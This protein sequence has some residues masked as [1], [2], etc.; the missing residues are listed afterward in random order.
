[1]SKKAILAAVAV[2]GV[3]LMGQGSHGLVFGFTP[4]YAQGLTLEQAKSTGVVGEQPDGLLGVVQ[5]SPAIDTLVKSINAQRLQKY[6]EIAGQQGT[7]IKNV[8]AI[9][10]QKLIER[11]QKGEK[12]LKDGQWI[13]R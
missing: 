1:M 2:S 11:L 4:V 6:Q 5:S 8:Q 10:G 12:Y 9:A 13:A 3:M 7:P